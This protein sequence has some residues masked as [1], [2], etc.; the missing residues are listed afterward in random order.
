MSERGDQFARE[1]PGC[2]L[3]CGCLA[4]VLQF[5]FFVGLVWLA[6]AVLRSFGAL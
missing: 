5:G 1:N 6:I 2:Y 3:G 4:L